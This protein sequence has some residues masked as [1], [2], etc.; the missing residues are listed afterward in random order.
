MKHETLLQCVGALLYTPDAPEVLVV[1]AYVCAKVHA[2][3]TKLI[4]DTFSLYCLL[5]ECAPQ[6]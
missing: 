1:Q 5:G 3:G 4:S 2:L 6:Q